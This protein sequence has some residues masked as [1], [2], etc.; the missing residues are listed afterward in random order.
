MGQSEKTGDCNTIFQGGL[1]A[2]RLQ[3]R[4]RAGRAHSAV[5]ERGTSGARGRAPAEDATHI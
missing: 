2:L 5:S 3:S 1:V 4:R